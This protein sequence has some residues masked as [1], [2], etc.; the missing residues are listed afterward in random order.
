MAIE[1]AFQ[2]HGRTPGGSAVKGLT[3]GPDAIRAAAKL[4]RIGYSVQSLKLDFGQS[5]RSLIRQ[6][7]PVEE[8]VRI[9]EFCAGAREAGSNAT[10][11]LLVAAELVFDPRLRQALDGMAVLIEESG[12]SF[13]LAAKQT[14]LFPCR[15]V[16]VMLAMESSGS[17]AEAL[18]TLADDHRRA[19]ER[20]RVFR[21][22]L[23]APIALLLVFYVLIYGALGF[24]LPTTAEAFMRNFGDHLPTFTAL[25]YGFA[26]WYKA[27]IVWMS[28]L[29]VGIGVAGVMF[30]RS[31]L[32]RRLILSFRLPYDIAERSDLAM[33]WSSFRLLYQAGMPKDD[34]LRALQRMATL[35]INRQRSRRYANYAPTMDEA[36]A[37]DKAKFPRYVVVA[38]KAGRS[39]TIPECLEKMVAEQINIVNTKATLLATVVNTGSTLFGALIVCLFVAITLLPGMLATLSNL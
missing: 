30:F 20:S 17:L 22:M 12:I 34:Q 23:M 6:Q 29:H 11:M 9:Y 36:V 26:I 8:L 38:L 16:E 13:G 15:D 3:F 33:M 25:I 24:I 5:L 19:D 35:D 18:R 14:G 39:G 2:Y 27:H 4:R 10:E 32:V 21:R 31:Q 7:I 28:F 1:L 37:A